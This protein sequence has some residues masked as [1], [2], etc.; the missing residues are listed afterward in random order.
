M[1][2]LFHSARA[3]PVNRTKVTNLYYQ[4]ATSKIVNSGLLFTRLSEYCFPL[5]SPAGLTVR[6]NPERLLRP[7]TWASPPAGAL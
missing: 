2:R 6:L 1:A 3:S 4:D 7:P 5:V